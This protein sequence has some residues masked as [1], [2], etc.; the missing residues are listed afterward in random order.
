MIAVPTSATGKHQLGAA[1]KSSFSSMPEG[2]RV[3]R[4]TKEPAKLKPPAIQI[5]F[6]SPY[7]LFYPLR[8]PDIGDESVALKIFGDLAKKRTIMGR[9]NMGHACIT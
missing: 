6:L 9:T 4:R 1:T 3:E 8:V 5:D 2:N 7:L